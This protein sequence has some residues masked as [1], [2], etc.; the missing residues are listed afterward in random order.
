MS[1]HKRITNIRNKA[2]DLWT[3][4]FWKFIESN[5]DKNFDW[6]WISK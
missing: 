3:L 2:F 6:K 5:E 4:V 1:R